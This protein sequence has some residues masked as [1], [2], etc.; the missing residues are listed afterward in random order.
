MINDDIDAFIS[1]GEERTAEMQRK[2]EGMSFED[3]SSFKSE[4]MVSQWKGEDFQ[5]VSARSMLL[6]ELE[7]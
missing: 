3:L 2:Y 5:K 6:P 1:K 7:C 4:A